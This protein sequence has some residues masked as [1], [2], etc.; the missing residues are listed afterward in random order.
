MY[1]D[2][3]KRKEKREK[4]E[5]R[6]GGFR[7][8]NCGQWVTF[9]EFMGTAHRNHCP[10]CLCSKHVDLE[11]P[12]DRK[13]DC[14]AGMKPIGLTFKHEGADKYGKPRQGELMIV[15]EC[16]GS[17]CGKVSINRIAADDSAEAILKIFEESQK[18]PKKWNQLKRKGIEILPSENREKVSIQLFGSGKV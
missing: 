16:T 8:C 6:K 13:A 10:F 17:G 7:C 9:S 5:E 18:H 3:E 14:S 11:K 1:K 15:H 4:K 2:E 12:G